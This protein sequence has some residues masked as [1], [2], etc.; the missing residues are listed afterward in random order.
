MHNRFDRPKQI[1]FIKREASCYELRR[2]RVNPSG[3]KEH[4][5][6]SPLYGTSAEVVVR[7]DAGISLVRSHPSHSNCFRN[8]A[9]WFFKS[10]ISFCKLAISA[11]SSVIRTFSEELLDMATVFT[12]GPSRTSTSPDN[13]CA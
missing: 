8:S 6:H 1:Q 11:S 3:K 2:A 10:A 4:S 5:Y 13:R 7:P 12:G 9:N